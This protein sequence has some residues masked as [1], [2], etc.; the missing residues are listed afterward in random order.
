MASVIRAEVTD[1]F[2]TV[3]EIIGADAVLGKL[4]R[5][6]RGRLDALVADLVAV[7][8]IILGGDEDHARKVAIAELLRLMADESAYGRVAERHGLLPL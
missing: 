4:S 3:A 7:L 8:T 5:H 6:Q 1:Q 2:G